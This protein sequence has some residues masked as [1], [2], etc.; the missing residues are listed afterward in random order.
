MDNVLLVKLFSSFRI[1]TVVLLSDAILYRVSPFWTVY[2]FCDVSPD[3]VGSFRVW[4]IVSALVDR[5]FNVFKTDTVVLYLFAI[6]YRVSPD[7][8]VYVDGV[9]LVVGGVYGIFLYSRID[10]MTASANSL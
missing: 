6:W 1:S 4:P 10:F 2:I 7:L 9:S 5:L 8:T 3:A